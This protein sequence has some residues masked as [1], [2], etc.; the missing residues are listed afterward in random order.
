ME[1]LRALRARALEPGKIDLF[2]M[3]V[4]E[5]LGFQLH[6]AVQHAKYELS[7]NREAIFSFQVPGIHVSQ[8]V[9]RVQFEEWISDELHAISSC[10]DQML[11]S[12]GVTPS[13]IDRVF[14]TGGSS[15]VP[16]VREIF[17]RRFGREL[18]VGGSEFTSV[19]NGLALRSLELSDKKQA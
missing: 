1:A 12:S 9:T 6:R 14:L 11:R 5:D 16:A 13:D 4:T 10:V 7:V 2:I 17:E 3:L 19:A 8:N 18:I 15:F